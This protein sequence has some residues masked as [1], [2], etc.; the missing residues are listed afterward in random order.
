MLGADK[1]LI[2]VAGVHAMAALADDWRQN[3]QT[4]IDVLCDY[5]RMPH[6]PDPGSVE[7]RRQF[8]ADHGVRQRIIRVIAEHLGEDARVSWND[9]VFDFTDTILY[10]GDF[11]GAR[12]NGGRVNFT[13][14][15]FKAGN[16]DF[17]KTDF[18]GAEILFDNTIFSGGTVSFSEAKFR[19]GFIQFSAPH[20]AGSNV[21]FHYAE[22]SGGTVRFDFANIAAG[23]VSFGG[24][25][26]SG[27]R[28]HFLSSGSSGGKLNFGYFHDDPKALATGAEFLARGSVMVNGTFNGTDIS[29]LG[30]HFNGGR[31]SLGQVSKWNPQ[32]KFDWKAGEDPPEG[33]SFEGL[34]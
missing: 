25:K 11:S 26:F 13:G 24:A 18:S 3:R 4:C 2:R 34:R 27:G 8:P 1:P 9:K 31:L 28:V 20:F 6:P 21:Y 15:E 17:S 30:A 23:V 32:P 12:F 5:L 33:V 29:F 19:D 16:I 22:F 14:A 10:G 7:E